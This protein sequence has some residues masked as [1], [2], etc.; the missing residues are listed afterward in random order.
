MPKPFVHC[1]MIHGQVSWTEQAVMPF[2]L[3]KHWLS[4]H[5][6]H[7]LPMPTLHIHIYL[8]NFTDCL[9]LLL[10]CHKY[11]SFVVSTFEFVKAIVL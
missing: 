3:C 6:K 2:I 10:L 11:I 8:E 4:V 9:T 7:S 1:S 5:S